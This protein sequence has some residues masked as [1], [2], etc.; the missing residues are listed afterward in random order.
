[1]QSFIT[2]NRVIFLHLMFWCTYISFI[3]YQIVFWQRERGYDW[4]RALTFTSLQLG[5]TL[6]I[7]YL[8]YFLFLP[9]FLQHKNFWK[10]LV[11]FLIPYA[12]L[13]V[14]RIYVQRHLMVDSPRADYY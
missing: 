2:R 3:G 9:R 8:N 10:Y 12:I 13:I 5:F 11:E 1:M 14:A 6:A 4:N 7:A